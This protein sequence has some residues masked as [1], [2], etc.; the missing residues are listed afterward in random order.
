MIAKLNKL[1][2]RLAIRLLYVIALNSNSLTLSLPNSAGGRLIADGGGLM[3]VGVN[4]L[5]IAGLMP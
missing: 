5:P 1:D 3:N 4:A 2:A